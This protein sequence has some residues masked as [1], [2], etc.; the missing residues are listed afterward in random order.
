MF[1]QRVRKWIGMWKLQNIPILGGCKWLE[2]REMRMCDRV[3]C[4]PAPHVDPVGRDGEDEALD[5]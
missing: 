5:Q 4:R 3:P 1:F 2:M